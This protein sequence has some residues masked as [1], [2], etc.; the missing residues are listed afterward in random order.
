MNNFFN[1]AIEQNKPLRLMNGEIA[2]VKFQLPLP[3]SWEPKYVGYRLT[4]E[5]PSRPVVET[6]DE[7]G[8]AE[9]NQDFNIWDMKTNL[10]DF[11]SR[12]LSAWPRFPIIKKD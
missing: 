8:K 7:L 4:G 10:R 12:K 5:Y 1:T 9:S 3:S 2:Y 6:W 11:T